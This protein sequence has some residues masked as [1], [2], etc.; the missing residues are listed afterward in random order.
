MKSSYFD[1]FFIFR[2][3]SYQCANKNKKS[4]KGGLK[5][6]LAD[7]EP[8]SDISNLNANLPTTAGSGNTN[9]GN[10]AKSDNNDGTKPSIK[11]IQSIH[12]TT[13]GKNNVLPKKMIDSANLIVMYLRYYLYSFKSRFY[14]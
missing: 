13:Y 8:V 9:N 12:S 6:P 5:A 10:L 7:P 4:E 2:S 1:F 3:V 14:I 11:A